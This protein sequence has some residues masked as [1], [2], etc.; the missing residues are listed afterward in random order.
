MSDKRQQATAA[1]WVSPVAVQSENTQGHAPTHKGEI[2]NWRVGVFFVLALAVA[3]ALAWLAMTWGTTPAVAV[4][5]VALLVVFTPFYLID[6]VLSSGYWHERARLIVEDNKTF[7]A[8]QTASQVNA[9]QQGQI[10]QLWTAIHHMDERL[11]AMDTIKI[12]G[13]DG[14]R[15]V[16]KHDEIDSDI[17]RW[18][19]SMFDANGQMVGAHPSGSLR[20]AY[21]FKG[22]GDGPRQAHQR[23]IRAGLVGQNATSKQYVWT[24]PMTLS[25]ARKRLYPT[26]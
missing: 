9:E 19:A 5:V 18:L 13:R 23:L 10:E 21:P 20:Q 7:A 14:V 12:Q 22:D 1:G 25:E 2:S 17:D 8:V 3:L 24:G 15:H 11:K 4:F 26:P 16:A 6:S